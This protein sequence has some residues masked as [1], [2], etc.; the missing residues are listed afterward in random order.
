MIDRDRRGSEHV[1]KDPQCF[2]ATNAGRGDCAPG[3][4]SQFGGRATAI[5][6]WR[7]EPNSIDRVAQNCLRQNLGGRVVLMHHPRMADG[8]EISRAPREELRHRAIPTALTCTPVRR[9][10]QALRVSPARLLSPLR[11]VCDTIGMQI[12]AAAE[13]PSSSIPLIRV[14]SWAWGVVAFS[15][16]AMYFVT[17]ENGAF[18][19]QLANTLHEFVH[20]G[21]HFAGVACH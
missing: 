21:R 11:H 14:P 15:A 1:A 9:L 16:V 6:R 12:L 4:R 8:E 17:L 20:D 2:E 5:E 19:G 3:H 18:L 7:V 10:A 13:P